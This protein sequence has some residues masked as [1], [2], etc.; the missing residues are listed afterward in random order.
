EK[1]GS[2][3]ENMLLSEWDQDE[4]LAVR[5]EEGR[6]EGFDMGLSKGREEGHEELFAL[7]EKGVSLEEARKKLSLKGNFV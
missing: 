4:A 5:Y 1:N 6:E 7:W 2:E 3:V